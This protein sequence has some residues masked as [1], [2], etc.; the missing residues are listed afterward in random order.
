[1]VGGV[2]M[3]VGSKSRKRERVSFEVH[4]ELSPHLSY[5]HKMTRD[6]LGQNHQ[7]KNGSIQP[8]PKKD[9]VNKH[10]IYFFSLTLRPEETKNHDT[11]KSFPP[12]NKK[13]CYRND[14]VSNV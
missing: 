10:E 13:Y 8:I 11:P 12:N 5:H 7:Q 9:T 3:F 14:G 2:F 6:G 4:F 1:M